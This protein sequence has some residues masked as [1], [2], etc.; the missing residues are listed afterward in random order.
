M[1]TIKFLTL[2]RYITAQRYSLLLDRHFFSIYF[3]CI[4]NKIRIK[5]CSKQKSKG[6]QN[7]YP[8]NFRIDSFPVLSFSTQVEHENF[9]LSIRPPPPL[10]FLLLGILS[11]ISIAKADG[12]HFLMIP[13]HFFSLS[14]LPIVVFLLLKNSL[15]DIR[16]L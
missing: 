3:F 5:M 12:I 11:F 13:S 8:S 4:R 2:W 14:P 6:I 16:V 10:S 1:I 7:R 9:I 15:R